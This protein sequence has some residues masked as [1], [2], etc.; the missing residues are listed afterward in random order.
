[1]SADFSRL[2]GFPGSLRGSRRHT[3][4]KKEKGEPREFP[5]DFEALV[6]MTTKYK[7]LQRLKMKLD[8]KLNS[9]AYNV[10]DSKLDTKHEKVDKKLE[11]INA[12][13]SILAINMRKIK[14]SIC[15]LQ[16]PLEPEYRFELTHSLGTQNEL[17]QQCRAL[18]GDLLQKSFGDSKYHTEIRALQ[19]SA[20]DEGKLVLVGLADEI[21]EGRWFFVDGS[22]FDPSKDG[23]VFIWADGEPNERTVVGTIRNCAYI[24]YGNNQMYDR[25]CDRAYYGLCEIRTNPSK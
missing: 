25:A 8:S 21:T 20:A 16:T 2:Q 23:N 17:R 5:S 19:Q 18:G 4:V 7:K 24:Y 13:L 12:K 9:L 6:S 1:L 14:N 15:M 10:V 11:R 3:D 22:S